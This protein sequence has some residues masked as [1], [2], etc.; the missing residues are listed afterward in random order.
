MLKHLSV[1][2]GTYLVFNVGYSSCFMVA[3]CDRAILESICTD[4]KASSKMVGSVYWDRF[5][6]V[7][8]NLRFDYA[9]LV[10]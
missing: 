5:Y 6:K 3:V 8:L 4:Y 9:V 1:H 2:L 7:C 10:S